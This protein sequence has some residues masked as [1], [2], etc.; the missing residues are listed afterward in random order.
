MFSRGSSSKEEASGERR[1]LRLP[2]LTKKT[3]RE[4][5]REGKKREEKTRLN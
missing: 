2:Y 4:G 1:F 5:K 3:R